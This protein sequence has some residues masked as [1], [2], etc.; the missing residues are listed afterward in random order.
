MTMTLDPGQATTHA[1][2][3]AATDHRPNPAADREATPEGQASA[4]S[5]LTWRSMSD[6]LPEV[7]S[8]WSGC[9]TRSFCRC[10]GRWASGWRGTASSSSCSRRSARSR[11]TGWRSPTESS[12]RCCR[13]PV[14]FSSRAWSGIVVVHRDPGLGRA[15]ALELLQGD[16]GLHRPRCPARPGRHRRRHGRN[17][18]AGRDLGGDQRAARYRNGGLP[19]RGARPAGADSSRA[20]SRR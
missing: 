20:S 18:R 5:A 17:P 16:D 2:G 6:Q 11:S 3:S 9:C 14:R 1:A 7:R 8:L 15:A 12:A 13:P 4:A 10:P 19:Q